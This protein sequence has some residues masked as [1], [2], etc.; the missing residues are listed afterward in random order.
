MAPRPAACEPSKGG[1]VNLVRPPVGHGQ[2]S[3]SHAPVVVPFLK[4]GVGKQ[5]SDR[6]PADEPG[7]AIAV[8]TAGT[9]I[10]LREPKTDKCKKKL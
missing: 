10:F 4:A 9:E 2:E 1:I 7:F 6:R 5:G 3:A 8:G